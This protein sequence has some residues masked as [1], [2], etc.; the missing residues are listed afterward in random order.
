MNILEVNC[1]LSPP[2]LYFIHFPSE[3]M[4]SRTNA[5]PLCGVFTENTYNFYFLYFPRDQV[6]STAVHSISFVWAKKQKTNGLQAVLFKKTL[7]AGLF[8]LLLECHSSFECS[9]KKKRKRRRSRGGIG[10]RRL[11]LSEKVNVCDCAQK[12]R[13][14]LWVSECLPFTE[15][16]RKTLMYIL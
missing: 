3:E 10:G 15:A 9:C 16:Q 2:R 5:K 8:R 6:L 14:H 4:L 12:W 7:H 13:F 1:V 11:W